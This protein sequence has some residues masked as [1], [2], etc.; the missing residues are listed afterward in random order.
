MVEEGVV[1]VT[2]ETAETSN[3]HSRHSGFQDPLGG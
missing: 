2:V 3:D 1:A